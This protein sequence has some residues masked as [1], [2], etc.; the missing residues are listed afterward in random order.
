MSRVSLPGLRRASRLRPESSGGDGGRPVHYGV[1][2]SCRWTEALDFIE[3]PDA[4]AQPAASI[5]D[6]ILKEIRA[7][8][9]FLQSVGLSYL[10]L[11]RASGTLSGG[12]SQ[13]IRLA[14]QIGS[15]PDGR[16]VYSGRA[17]HRP[18]PAGQRQA[19]G[20]AASSLRDLGNTLIVVEHDEDTMRAADY[21]VDIGPG[22]G[23]HG[24]RDR[25]RRHAGGD[26]G[27]SQ[28]PDGPV[29]LGGKKPFPCRRSAARATGK[30]ADRSGRGGE[31]PEEHRRIR[32]AGH[33]HLRHR[34]VRL[35]E[36]LSGQRDHLYKRLAAELNRMKA[37]ARPARRAWRAWSIWTR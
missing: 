24:G 34:R 1:L 6:Q 7:R 36:I 11:S 22:A 20:H 12:E 35:R 23:V 2:P 19:A 28:Q 13:R 14:T 37:R 8:L 30:L 25:G 17:V 3:R 26:H 18:A 27:L 33:L 31:Q 32:S 16:A 9:G 4:D 15:Q 29:S 10:T 5:A 21:L